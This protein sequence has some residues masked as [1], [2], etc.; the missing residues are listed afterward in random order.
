MTPFPFVTVR[1]IVNA[2]LAVVMV[3]FVFWLIFRFYQ[4]VLI[5]TLAVLVSTSLKPIVEWLQQ[6]GIPS[7]LGVI[8]VYLVLLALVVT[9]FIV[10]FPFIAEQTTTITTTL[11]EGYFNF[12]Q[13][14]LQVPSLPLRRLAAE[15]PLNLESVLETAESTISDEEVVAVAM[16]Q[17]WGFM[18]QVARILMGI[19]AVFIL[20]FY[21]TLESERTKQL[22]FLLIP[23]EK[24]PKAREL[25]VTI[26]DRVGNYIMGQGILCLI[27]GGVSFLA[28]SFIGLPYA[29][30]LG[31]IAGITEA[32]P[33][34]GP[35][36]GAIPAVMLAFSISPQMVAGVIVVTVIIQQLENSYLFPRIIGQA[37]GT[38]PLVTLLSLF[39]FSTLFGV[40]GALVAIPLASVIQAL[41]DHLVLNPAPSPKLLAGGRDRVNRMRYETQALVQDIRSQIRHKTEEATAAQDHIEDSLEAIAL[42]LDDLLARQDMENGRK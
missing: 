2:T 29:L 30:I 27:V 9:I 19:G 4:V 5:F 23:M 21:W 22:L 13:S 17:A 8:L 10:G 34:V 18:G 1:S 25:V 39:A 26:E 14:I 24:R 15:L 41:L 42:N 12:R 32:I 31:I 37:V 35:V 28:Y 36:L 11:D 33:M 16:A 7:G 38:S 6:R 3:G 20:A 40:I